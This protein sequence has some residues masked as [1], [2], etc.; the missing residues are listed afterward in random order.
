MTK[1]L[2]NQ[3]ALSVD[4]RVM[5]VRKLDVAIDL[6]NGAMS[7]VK[8]IS[9]TESGYVCRVSVLFDDPYI[10]LS[11]GSSAH[12]LSSYETIYIESFGHVFIY[13]GRSIVRQAFPLVLCWAC[14][15]QTVQGLTLDTCSIDLGNSIFQS[16]M[17]YVALSRITT[18]A[19][20]RFRGVH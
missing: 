15:F 19:G 16:G 18:G 6:V 4:S 17:V 5:L 13:N 14:T 7:T 3:L 2:A 11:A 12:S 1:M 10:G 9:C 20:L 8:T